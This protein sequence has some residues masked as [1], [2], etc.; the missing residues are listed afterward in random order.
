M[1]NNQKQHISKEKQ[2][3]QR[4]IALKDTEEYKEITKL[5]FLCIASGEQL[6]NGNLVFA[7]I[8][9]IRYFVF[10]SGYVKRKIDN[11]LVIINPQIAYKKADSTK[12]ILDSEHQLFKNQYR[13]MLALIITNIKEN[14]F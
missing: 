11:D 10:K 5:N 13:K 9:N 4:L 1:K 2:N 6:N 14:A 12:L 7:N 8:L 3:M